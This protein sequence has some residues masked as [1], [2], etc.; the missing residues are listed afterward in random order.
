MTH[1]WRE[2]LVELTVEEKLA[3]VRAA[4]GAKLSPPQWARRELLARAHVAAAG[5]ELAEAIAAD[6]FTDGNGRTVRRLAMEYHEGEATPVCRCAGWAR[7]PVVARVAA[8][9]RGAA[10]RKEVRRD[11]AGA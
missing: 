1:Q 8:I 6:L 7:G 11:Q 3:I 10:L 4:K 5:D 9:L 2:L